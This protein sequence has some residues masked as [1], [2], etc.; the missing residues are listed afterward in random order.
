MSIAQRLTPAPF[1]CRCGTLH[2]SPDG[3]LPV[4]WTTRGG[5]V[6]CEDCTRAGVPVREATQPRPRRKPLSPRYAAQ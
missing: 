1:E 4:G 3:Q 5:N 6:W 2:A